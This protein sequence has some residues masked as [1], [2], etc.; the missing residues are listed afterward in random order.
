V[1]TAPI[2]FLRI[3]VG[4]LSVLFAYQ[5]GKVGARLKSQRLPVAKAS[6]WFLRVVVTVFAV[7]WVG[8]IDIITVATI[9]V[10]TFAFAAGIWQ[11]YKP[12]H[13]DSVHLDLQ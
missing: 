11:E 1:R 8:G 7:F 13:D 2:N 5:L 12:K 3:F 4:I 6:T 9:A 10:V